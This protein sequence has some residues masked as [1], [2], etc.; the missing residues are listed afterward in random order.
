ML[1]K[2][3][4]LN[5]VEELNKAA[6]GLKEEGDVASIIV[7]AEENGLDKADAEDYAEGEMEELGKPGTGEVLGRINKHTLENRADSEEWRK[8]RMKPVEKH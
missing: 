3:G 2:F 4:E 8:C 1:E 5:S 6:A 7:L